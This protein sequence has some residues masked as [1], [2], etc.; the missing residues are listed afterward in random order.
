MEI[1]KDY[2]LFRRNINKTDN[3]CLVYFMSSVKKLKAISTKIKKWNCRVCHVFENSNYNKK[4]TYTLTILNNPLF[5]QKID[6][7]D[8]LPFNEITK[9]P[10]ACPVTF[11]TSTQWKNIDNV[12]ILSNNGWDFYE[13]EWILKRWESSLGIFDFDNFWI[14]STYPMDIYNNPVHYSIVLFYVKLFINKA[15]L[16]S[17]KTKFHALYQFYKDKLGTMLLEFFYHETI[18]PTTDKT[19]LYE[20]IHKLYHKTNKTHPYRRYLFYKNYCLTSKQKFKLNLYIQQYLSFH[21]M[22][23]CSD[24]C[25]YRKEQLISGIEKG[26][27]EF[28]QFFEKKEK[29][30]VEEINLVNEYHSSYFQ[31]I[32]KDHIK[33]IKSPFWKYVYYNWTNIPRNINLWDIR[34]VNYND[35]QMKIGEDLS[36]SFP[37]DWVRNFHNKNFS[38]EIKRK[39]N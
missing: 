6:F 21:S 20:K 39:K 32:G 23:V 34:V 1:T 22:Y 18:N 9:N 13:L 26:N 37:I 27:M 35:H 10:Q 14:A 4:A 12:V 16:S 2:I 28:L 7:E 19:K 31:W 38:P 8:C 25:L 30:L 24:F 5:Y 33:K 36:S 3:D 17:M 11:N 29:K 15:G